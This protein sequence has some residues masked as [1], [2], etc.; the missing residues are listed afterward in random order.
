V[1]HILLP[2]AQYY[3]QTDSNTAH[4]DRMCFSSTMAMGIKYLCPSAL[5]GHN[6]DDQYL[7]TVLK[8]GDTTNSQAQ[9]KAAA[10]YNVKATFL[11]N[12]NVQSLYDRLFA[13]IPVPVGFLHHGPASA[14]RGGGHWILL[15]GA[16]DTHGIF[17]DPYGE[18]D[19]VNGGY[20]RRGVG[21]KSVSYSWKNW[22]KRWAVDGPNTGWFMDLRRI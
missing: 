4:A 11:T 12:G 20:P 9:I 7:Q 17:H 16:T 13:G 6:A 5:Y 14:P 8:F 22:T 15:I 21:G 2:V 18:L 3:P 10:Q 19:N 1:T